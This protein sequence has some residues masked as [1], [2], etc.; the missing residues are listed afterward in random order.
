MNNLNVE[1]CGIKLK[2]P[3]IAASG[4]F[5]FGIEYKDYVDLNKIGA[6]AV[7]GLTLKPKAGNPPP[8]IAETPSGILNS[9]GLQ[10]P[11]VDY[12][13]QNELPKLS[14]Y[15]VPIIANINGSTIDEYCQVAQKLNDQPI[16]F[17]ELNIS[18]PNVKEGGA[19][20][21]ARPESIYKVTKDVKSCTKKPL[22]V[23]LTPN[24]TNIGENAAAAEEGGADSISLVNTFLGMAIDAKSRRPILANITGGLSGPAIK[25]LALRMVWEA[26]RA[27][28]IPVIGMGGIMNGEDV[29]EFLLAGATA[30]MVGTAN[31]VTPNA[32]IRILDELSRYMID[33]SIKDISEL[34][35]GIIIN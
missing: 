11:G 9:V 20:F 30:V 2:N 13:I 4:T 29:V 1:I 21:G 27:V 15:D 12:F 14:E 8:R 34:I 25:P 32:C 19:A 26:N 31:L 33:N 17:I 5:G 16:S 35:N 10:N 22:I 7:K 23:K 18:C 6:I 3:I 24:T 28:S